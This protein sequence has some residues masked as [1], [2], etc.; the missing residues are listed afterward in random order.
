MRAPCGP[1][2]S[3]SKSDQATPWNPS[4]LWN[5]PFH[6]HKVHA[7]VGCSS[8]NDWAWSGVVRQTHRRRQ[9]TPR[10]AFCG[11]QTSNNPKSPKSTPKLCQH[12][13]REW[14]SGVLHPGF[15]PAPSP[16]STACYAV[17]RSCSLL[18]LL[19]H[20]LS[21]KRFSWLKNPCSFNPHLAPAS[22][23]THSAFKNSSC[24]YSEKSVSSTQ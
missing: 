1:S 14:Q 20:F 21:H 2:I 23:R 11:L 24:L 22:P 10:M 8:T 7:P 13:L 18:W 17:W 5:P 12:L 6:L 9:G 19:L 3:G 15:L 4:V 16:Q